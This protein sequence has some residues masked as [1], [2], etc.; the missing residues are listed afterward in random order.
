MVCRATI[1]F[2]ASSGRGCSSEWVKDGP[3]EASAIATG[4]T[5]FCCS[6][7]SAVQCSLVESGTADTDAPA[8]VS[9]G[10]GRHSKLVCWQCGQTHSFDLYQA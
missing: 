10:S 9:G 4:V 7:T 5:A 6:G 2:S 8:V 1:S 3:E